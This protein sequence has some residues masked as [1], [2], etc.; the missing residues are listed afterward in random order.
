[1]YPF[2]TEKKIRNRTIFYKKPLGPEDQCP[3]F[4]FHQGRDNHDD[5]SDGPGKGIDI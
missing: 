5:N 4:L 1:M 3:F 2:P